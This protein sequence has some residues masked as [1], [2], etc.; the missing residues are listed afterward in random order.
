[1]RAHAEWGGGFGYWKMECGIRVSRERKH[2]DRSRVSVF[3]IADRPTRVLQGT[4]GG[5]V[6][7]DYAFALCSMLSLSLN[8]FCRGNSHEPIVD[9]SAARR[10]DGSEGDWRG[11][12]L[13]GFEFG[14]AV[15]MCV[16]ICVPFF[17][18][19]VSACASLSVCVCVCVCERF[20]LVGERDRLVSTSPRGLLFHSRREGLATLSERLFLGPCREHDSARTRADSSFSSW[21]K[22]SRPPRRKI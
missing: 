20:D 5:R 21:E 12:G 8:V 6:R 11:D 18:L 4:T 19:C 7:S 1:M 15:G 2:S 3:G 22:E 14:V 10:S 16:S 9:Q 17:C 13:S